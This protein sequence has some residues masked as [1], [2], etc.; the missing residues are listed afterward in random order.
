MTFE[1]TSHRLGDLLE[2]VIDHRG[3]T[4]K[5]LGGDFTTSGVRVISAK[6]V[7][8]GCIRKLSD[9]RYV[10]EQMHAAWMP[11]PLRRGDVL[12]TSEAPLGEVVY[13]RDDADFCLGQRLFALRANPEVLDSRYLSFLLRSP[14]LQN[15]LLAR[16]SG[17]TAQGIRQ[18]ELVRVEVDIPPLSQ[19]RRIAAVLGS[20]DDKIELNRRI[21]RTLESIVRVIF[22]SWFVDFHPVRN[23]MEGKTGSELGLPPS[24]AALFPDTLSDSPIGPAPRGWPIVPLSDLVDVNPRYALSQGSETKYVDMASL[25]TDA[26]RVAHWRLRP[27]QSGSRFR[28]GD[29]LVA[30]ITPCLENGKTALV[31]FLSPG[32]TGWGSTEFLVLRAHPP[33]S[34]EYVYFLARSDAFR[35]HAVGSMSGSSG[36]QRVPAEALNR[37]PTVQPPHRLLKA[38]GE[39]AGRVVALMRTNDRSSQVLAEI[40]DALLPRLLGG[41]L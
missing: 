36:R 27:F 20:L 9:C 21:S 29:V 12:L 19:Q 31:D 22:K 24:L 34:A 28:N 4:P 3:R 33:L 2:L 25:P 1:L 41:A 17:T 32:E 7:K 11:N 26:P 35:D 30:R 15:R 10:S 38:F 8:D 13:L 40:R 16:A 39:F 5:K 37:F 23:K 14:E 18:A 6:N